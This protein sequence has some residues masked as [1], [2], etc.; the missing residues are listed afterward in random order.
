MDE[1]TFKKSTLEEDLK[2]LS[3]D[4]HELKQAFNSFAQEVRKI[5]DTEVPLVIRLDRMERAIEQL[6]QSQNEARQTRTQILGRVIGGLILSVISFFG[7]G[8][9]IYALQQ[10]GVK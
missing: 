3:A 6:Q 1:T 8:G 5:V 9:L 2:R 10:Y 7:G 4:L